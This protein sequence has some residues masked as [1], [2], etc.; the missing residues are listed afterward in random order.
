MALAAL[1]ERFGAT[2]QA[3]HR[4]A[5][6]I[7]AAARKPDNEIALAITPGGFGTPP[8]EFEGRAIQ[9]RVD[10]AE[11]VVEEDGA[12]R[13]AAISNLADAAEF[14]GQEL[15]LT[16]APDDASRLEVDPASARVLAELYALGAGVLERFAGELPAEATA[17]SPILWPEHFDVAIEAGDEPSGARATYG[18]SPGDEDHAEPYAYV[19]VWS[20]EADGEL[21]N[22]TGFAGAELGYAE[23]RERDDPGAATADFFRARYQA[24]AAHG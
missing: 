8:F 11:L 22:A 17:T 24:L 2:R 6:R 23:L 12:E 14:V 10:G 9:V 20:G 19:S 21:W 7:V 15:F 18:V 16:G 13:R 4:V 5:D 1:P 3:L